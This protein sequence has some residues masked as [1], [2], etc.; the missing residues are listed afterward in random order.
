MQSGTVSNYIINSRWQKIGRFKHVPLFSTAVESTDRFSLTFVEL[1]AHLLQLEEVMS[2][3][4][5]EI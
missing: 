5:A 3:P 2:P 4:A 1:S